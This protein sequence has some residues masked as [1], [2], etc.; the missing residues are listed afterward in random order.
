[1]QHTTRA[2]HDALVASEAGRFVLV[3]AKQAQSP[4]N[5][6]ASYAAAKAAAEAWT[7]AL[8]DGLTGTRA[9]ANII[10]VDAILTPAMREESPGEEFAAFTP[11]E[12][13]ADGIEFLCS[14]AAA[15]MN[16][17]RLPLTMG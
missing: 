11:A 15:E 4:S 13:I 10:V 7:L 2:F 3:S 14:D 17:Q 8:A 16:G 6:N 12:H 9:T 1:V 5:T